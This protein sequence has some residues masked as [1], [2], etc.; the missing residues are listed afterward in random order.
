MR[1]MNKYSTTM[2]RQFLIAVAGLAIVVPSLTAAVAAPAVAHAAAS[3]SAQATVG[4]FFNQDTEVSPVD[5][6]E[7]VSGVVP[8]IET[9]TFTNSGRF[10]VTKSGFHVEGI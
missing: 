10:V 4:T 7:C 3:A 2:I 5:G 9:A 8:G 6:T 1:A